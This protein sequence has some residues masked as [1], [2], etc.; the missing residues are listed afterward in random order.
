MDFNLIKANLNLYAVIKNL[1]DLTLHDKEMKELIS[2]WNLSIQF[3]VRNGPKG[4]IEF[5]DGKCSVGRGKCKRPSIVLYFFSPLHLNK[6]F[7]GTAN[8]VPLKGFSKIRFLMKDFPKL[9][10][11]LAYYLKPE[12]DL[13]K[14]IDYL[15]I[16]TI[17]LMN[18]AAFAI[19]E[20]AKENGRGKIIASHIPEG[21]VEMKILPDF[22][23]LNI[24]FS[25]SG[26][27]TQKGK[28]VRPSAV[29]AMKNFKIANDFLNGKTDPFT[30][31]ASGDVMIKGNIPMLDAMSLLLDR[32]PEY[33]S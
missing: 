25:S 11:R 31:I 6:M 20:I 1:E 9:T 29:M 28:A 21:I 16:N 2:K 3:I 26:I 18:T 14:N 4:Y 12:N 23:S 32:I 22:H 10:D 24:S 17:M 33:I 27:V 5:A 30:A 8:P 15:K 7:D 19:P 13:L